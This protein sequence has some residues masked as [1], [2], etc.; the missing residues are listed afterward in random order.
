MARRFDIFAAVHASEL[1]LLP[2][3]AAAPIVDVIGLVDEDGV[4]GH[5]DVNRDWNIDFCCP[6]WRIVGCPI[7]HLDLSVRRPV[8][9]QEFTRYRHAIRPDSIVRMQI[10]LV[11]KRR[12]GI[13]RGLLESFESAEKCDPELSEL[14]RTLRGSVTIE[15]PLFGSVALDSIRDK[16]WTIVDW[17]DRPVRLQLSA[18]QKPGGATSVGGG[19]SALAKPGGMERAGLGL[20]AR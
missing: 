14:R 4:Q 2:L 8:T 17:C 16:F 9:H 15:D 18:T 5:M 13:P 12:L 20:P 6:A 11:D 1:R 10:R 7:Q 19:P 3:L